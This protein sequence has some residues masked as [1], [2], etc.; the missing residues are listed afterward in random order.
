MNQPSL[1]EGRALC[2]QL[3]ALTAEMR[4]AEGD[5]LLALECEWMYVWR[6]LN[7]VANRDFP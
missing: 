7:E 6:A 1:N 3:R 5:A 4:D 2:A